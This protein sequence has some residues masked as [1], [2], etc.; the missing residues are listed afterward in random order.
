MES[1]SQL[2]HDVRGL[3]DPEAIK[4]LRARS[5]RLIDIGGGTLPPTT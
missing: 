2:A 4:G 5:N 3:L 1:K